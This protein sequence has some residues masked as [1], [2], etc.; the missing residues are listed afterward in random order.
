MP[1]LTII[2]LAQRAGVSP[3]T[4]SRVLNK[5]PGVRAD[6]RELIE[7]LITETGF[8]PNP[9]ARALQGSR[10]Y[11]IGLIFERPVTHYYQHELQMGA[12]SACRQAGYHLVI[13]GLAELRPHGMDYLKQRLITSRFDGVILPPPVGD[14]LEIMA[15]FDDLNVPYVRISPTTE[16]ENSPQVYIDDEQAAFDATS[17][18]IG[19]GHRRLAY[20]ENLKGGGSNL[21]RK[22]GFL[23]A[24]THHG[25][26]L[27]PEW[28]MR[29]DPEVNNGFDEAE[30]LLSMPDRPTAIFAAADY[31]AFGALAAAAKLKLSVPDDVSIVGF[32]NAPT[33]SSV[34]PPLTSV[35][36]PMND[37]GEAATRLL[38]DRLEGRDVSTSQQLDYHLVRRASAAAPPISA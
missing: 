30:A 3:K 29:G 16:I 9:A 23:R 34:W 38:I 37:L 8:K 19:L 20:I 35:H 26:E 15:L 6:K 33:A 36:Q 32:D 1:R 13:E 27:H 24:M 21:R 7:R 12:L 4:I 2:D 18:L 14:D 22:A 31:I 28:V 17:W 11:M 5:E 25:L 10:S